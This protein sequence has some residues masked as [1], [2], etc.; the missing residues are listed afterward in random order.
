MSHTRSLSATEEEKLED[1]IAADSGRRGIPD[2][3]VGSDVDAEADDFSEPLARA[4]KIDYSIH[5]DVVASVDDG[6]SDAPAAPSLAHDDS[7]ESELAGAGLAAY[8][9]MTVPIAPRAFQVAPSVIPPSLPREPFF[10]TWS[11]AHVYS[12]PS[13][14]HKALSTQFV[15]RDIDF[16]FSNCDWKYQCEC[17]ADEF[18]ELDL[19]LP[20]PV[21]EPLQRSSSARTT[22]SSSDVGRSKFI[23]SVWCADQQASHQVVEF[24]NASSCPPKMFRRTFEGV[25]RGVARTAG[26]AK[27]LPAGGAAT[28]TVQLHQPTAMVFT[29]SAGSTSSTPKPTNSAET[30]PHISSRPLPSTPAGTP[31]TASSV[32]TPVARVALPG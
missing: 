27:V 4:L 14:L 23:V 17:T 7:F 24:S 8:G 3:A 31:V 25:L 9:A 32:A 6:L 10:L 1:W 5:D 19:D 30:S 15:H 12:A 29:P 13:V 18:A 28:D 2:G 16:T 26:I 21:S 22:R 20:A 11:H